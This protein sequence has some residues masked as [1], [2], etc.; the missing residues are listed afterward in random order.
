MT[1]FLLQNYKTDAIVLKKTVPLPKASSI[2]KLK[3]AHIV[4]I[5]NKEIF[6]NE[7]PVAETVIVKENEWWEIVKLKT[8]LQAEIK[9]KKEEMESGLKNML[10]NAAKDPSQ[11]T[12]EE[13]EEEEA[14]RYAWGRVTL[15]ADK[16][17]DMLTVKKV[18]YT[19]TEAGASLINFAVTE[20]PADKID[21]EE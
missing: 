20:V 11:M 16:D 21:L 8:G 2:K 15:Q 9:K 14:K 3:P 12:A 6:L 19:I 5:T 10:K 1:V 13:R 7:D 18:M 4:V 17:I